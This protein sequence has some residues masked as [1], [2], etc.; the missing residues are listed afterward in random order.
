LALCGVTTTADADSLLRKKIANLSPPEEPTKKVAIKEALLRNPEKSAKEANR[1]IEIETV[2]ET[3][4]LT[5]KEL[6]VLSQ[7]R[8]EAV[9]DFLIKEGGVDLKR[10]I[11]CSS[12]VDKKEAAKPHVNFSLWLK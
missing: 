8:G 2:M 4:E 3:I 6:L 7:Q 5:D 1:D 9:K 10:L 11:L 12:G